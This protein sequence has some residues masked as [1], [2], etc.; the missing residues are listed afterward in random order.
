VLFSSSKPRNPPTELSQA[1]KNGAVVA[2]ARA[3][4]EAALRAAVAAGGDPAARSEGESSLALAIDAAS[5]G[6]VAYLLPMND[7]EALGPAS[8]TPLHH[9]LYETARAET[10]EDR[11]RT[12]RAAECIGLVGRHLLSL[13]RPLSP[14]GFTAPLSMAAGAGSLA[15]VEALLRFGDAARFTDKSLSASEA[16]FYAASGGHA[17]CLAA[18]IE[19]SDP[20]AVDADGCTPLHRA[21]MAGPG[22]EACV[23]ALIHVSDLAFQGRSGRHALAWAQKMIHPRATRLLAGA[24][25]WRWRGENAENLV[26]SPLPNRKEV[27]EGNFEYLWHRVSDRELALRWRRECVQL[28]L[29][30]GVD[31]NEPDRDG[32]SALARAGRSRDVEI[33]RLLA[34]LC[35]AMAKDVDGR[36][37]F[38]YSFLAPA[39]AAAILR[40]RDRSGRLV[41]DLLRERLASELNFPIVLLWQAATFACS[42]GFWRLFHIAEQIHGPFPSAQVESLARLAARENTPLAPS[43]AAQAEA[44]VLRESVGGSGA[45]DSGRSA[46]SL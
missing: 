8:L 13:G 20:D 42:E 22:A 9:A 26:S 30:H 28:A 25:D 21:V 44:S 39:S 35:D 11:D 5:P 7:P 17:A 29:D 38:L 32:E 34:P 2:A 15:A 1:E 6:C 45:S 31:P 19:A 12:A 3:G 41:E 40:L 36:P 27:E 46:R 14:A 33:L 18:L 16:L 37:A 24:S 43:L 23:E 10:G 4:D